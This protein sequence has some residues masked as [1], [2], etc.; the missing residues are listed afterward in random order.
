MNFIKNIFPKNLSLSELGLVLLIPLVSFTSHTWLPV[1]PTMLLFLG[2]VVCWIFLQMK[3]ESRIANSVLKN[4][5]IIFS[6]FSFYLFASQYLMGANFRHYMGAVFAPLYLVLILIFSERTSE[7]FLKNLGRKFIFY[8]LIILSFEAVGRYAFNV[9]QMF[10]TTGQIYTFYQFKFGGPMYHASNATATHLVAL[11]FFIFWWG[12]T[13]KQSMKKEIGVALVLIVLA[14]SRAA[15]PA[16]AIG[17]FYYFFL[18]NL[19]WKKSILA[20]FLIGIFGV[21]ALLNLRYLIPDYSFQSKFVLV[22]EAWAYYQTADIVSILF[23][24]GFHESSNIL[25]HFAHNHFLIFL[26]ESGVLGLLFLCA[27]FFVL[28]KITNGAAMIVLVPFLVQTMA[29]SNTF[30]PYFYVIMALMLILT[31][32]KI[33]NDTKKDTLLLD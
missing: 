18:K 7:D 14:L 26:M 17:L 13:Y 3:G 23:G 10:Q 21:F 33:P 5:V 6:A 24:V 31:K 30:T 15:I 12:N 2:A 27:T 28:I 32:P 19:D 1:P 11:L 25:S 8:S 4:I 29:D 16:V 20:L 22:E 9:Y